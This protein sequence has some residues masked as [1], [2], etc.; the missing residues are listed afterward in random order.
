MPC[1]RVLTNER[2]TGVRLR[3]FSTTRPI[4]V[5]VG[6]VPEAMHWRIYDDGVVVMVPATCETHVLHADLAPVFQPGALLISDA[7]QKER[8]ATGPGGWTPDAVVLQEALFAQLWQ[9][10]I[11]E[12]IDL[13]VRPAA[14]PQ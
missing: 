13:P 8:V 5:I 1:P 14:C 6:R 9:L 4:N 2:R 7:M 12:R 10:Q 11:I 3:L